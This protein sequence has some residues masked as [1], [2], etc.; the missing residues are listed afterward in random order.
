MSF[1]ESSIYHWIRLEGMKS[2]VYVKCEK[3]NDGSFRA[4][5]DH[6]NEERKYVSGYTVRASFN[7]QLDYT[8]NKLE[9]VIEFV[10]A[11]ASCR[12]HTKL[13]CYGMKVKLSKTVFNG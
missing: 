4:F 2:A 6:N 8:L 11:A 12:Q 7:R 5:V 9:D 10:N 1:P 3:G 13:E